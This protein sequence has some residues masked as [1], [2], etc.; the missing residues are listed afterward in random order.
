MFTPRPVIPLRW[1]ASRL[2]FFLI[3]FIKVTPRHIISIIY[4]MWGGENSEKYPLKEGIR[5]D[6]NVVKL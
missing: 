6:E 3:R 5:F 1:I 4:C 2:S